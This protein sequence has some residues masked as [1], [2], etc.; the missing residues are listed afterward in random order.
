[1]GGSVSG[2][3]NYNPQIAENRW[4]RST[5]VRNWWRIYA[6][7]TRWAPPHYA[8]LRKMANAADP[9]IARQNPLLC[10][11]EAFPGR[12]R[13]SGGMEFNQPAAIMD[14][15]VA[16]AMVLSDPRRQDGTAYLSLLR[17]VNDVESLERFVGVA[18]EQAAYL[19]RYRLVGPTGLSPH[20]GSGVL[21]DYFHVVPPLHTAY[22]PPYVPEVMESVLAPLQT[23]RLYHAVVPAETPA[24][25]G[26]AQ[27]VHLSTEACRKELIHLIVE[28]FMADGE[29]P[30]PDTEE[31]AFLLRWL[32][33]WPL[34]AWGAVVDGRLA[35][36]AIVQPDL[37]AAAARA[38]GGKSVL[39][40][41]WLAW[42]SARPVTAGRLLLGGVL[43]ADR[44]RGIGRQLWGQA[45]HAAHAAGW[46][47]L[48]A[49]PLPRMH[50][51]AR[52][53][54]ACGAEA[55]QS[56]TVYASEF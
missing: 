9:F 51:A 14:V 21:Q 27:I 6:G 38:R 29:F 44:G 3:F 42:R 48:S 31:A 35:G 37:A 41:L 54:A 26:P 20:L 1:M 18:L 22:N 11:L 52:F 34:T 36:Y 23:Q 5:F 30:A 13:T 24:A 16:A 25:Q 55:R 19:G 7:D 47:T 45:M 32:A 10:S 2:Y 17:C 43:P 8:L 33:A 15:P 53:L 28:T 49:G 50:P 56:Y 4:D 12:R 39:W 46:R 40:R